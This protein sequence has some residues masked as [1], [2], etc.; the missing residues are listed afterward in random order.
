MKTLTKDYRQ[1]AYALRQG[2]VNLIV[3]EEGNKVKRKTPLPD[4]D[5]TK[6]SRTVVAINL[7]SESPNTETVSSLF[8]QCGEITMMQILK[9]GKA[10]PTD[11]KKHLLKH[12]EIGNVVCAVIEFEKH[13]NALRAVAMSAEGEDWEKGL[14]VVMLAVSKPKQAEDSESESEFK[15]KKPNKK[16]ALRS[17]VLE[18]EHDGLSS[19]SEGDFLMP[20]PK[21]RSRQNSFDSNSSNGSRGGYQR[22][23][24]PSAAEKNWR[25]SGEPAL[26]QRRRSMPL[27]QSPLADSPAKSS[28]KASPIASPHTSPCASPEM[29]RRANSGGARSSPDGSP[30][31]SP[32]V[33]RRMQAAANRE[34]SPL[35]KGLSG[36]RGRLDNIMRTPRGPEA[37]KGFYCGKGRGQP[38]ATECS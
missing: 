28:P 34:M 13:E 11:I 29:R 20:R 4:Y 7:P 25:S 18:R 17:K 33:Q 14:R 6:V 27:P 35:A 37:G 24:S 15:Q 8:N 5:E 23:L 16:K 10:I 9:P 31:S 12:P 19:G 32:W 36:S 22:N 21:P 38:C 1:V 30:S 3:N 2:A 26:N